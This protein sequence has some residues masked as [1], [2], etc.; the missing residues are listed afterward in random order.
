FAL[1][2]AMAAVGLAPLAKRVAAI[3]FGWRET[4]KTG[5][6]LAAGALVLLAIPL[7]VARVA[8]ALPAAGPRSD[9]ASAVLIDVLAFMMG[10][11]LASRPELVARRGLA[12]LGPPAAAIVVAL[13]WRILVG[14][15]A[16]DAAIADRAPM[17]GLLVEPLLAPKT[18]SAPGGGG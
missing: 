10:A 12:L 1:A 8:R 15:P 16:L 4:G 13:G 2:A 11:L 9:E 6:L 14:A 17:F 7:F 18:A 3:A 5:R